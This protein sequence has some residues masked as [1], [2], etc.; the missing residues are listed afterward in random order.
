MIDEE[1]KL[2]NRFT[3]LS[4]RSLAHGCYTYS[5]FLTL[6][7]QSTLLALHLEP[8][9]VLWGGY[10]AAERRIA[11]FGNE[12]LCG[13]EQSPPTAWVSV[14]PLSQKFA[15]ELTHR[16]FLG[17]LIGLGLRR[18]VI[19][20]IIVSKNS[21]FVCCLDTVAQFICDNLERIKHTSAKAEIIDSPPSTG[22]ELP[23]ESELVVAG[24]RADAIIAAVYNLSRNES[25]RL[26]EQKKVFVNSRLTESPSHI[27]KQGNTVSV[28]GFG[29]FIFE[30]VKLE[31]RKGKLRIIVRIYP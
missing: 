15:D 19:G 29:R 31:T 17:T 28:R 23:P 7:E 14:S 8:S 12:E 20:D 16:D 27:L 22:C 13:Y 2:K 21:G 1:Q 18:E 4:Q 9:P 26:F 24:E 3:E 5:E 10:D 25:Q 11:C 6:A 30:C